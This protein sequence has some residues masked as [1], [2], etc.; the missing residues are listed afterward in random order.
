[1]ES[2]M[3]D[4]SKFR[5]ITRGLFT[6]FVLK[7]ED[8]RLNQPLYVN[9]NTRALA[10]F[11]VRK[12]AQIV[13][14]MEAAEFYSE[15]L[16]NSVF[17]DSYL[18]HLKEMAGRASGLGD[19]AFLEFGVASGTTIRLIAGVCQRPVVGFDWFKGLPENWRDGRQAGSFS[20]E[21]P[22]VPENVSLE[23]GLIEDTLPQWLE[24]SPPAEINFIHVDTDLYRPAKLIL[25]QCAPFMNNTI[26]VFDEFYNYPGWK[27]HE[28]KAFNEFM[29]E[30]PEFKSEYIGAG[31]K[32]SVSVHVTR[33][34]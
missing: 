21:I 8:K 26:I 3:G 29:A 31:G 11:D 27:H 28:Y 10:S 2:L 5:N 1:M 33:I 19:G 6:N 15:H 7:L 14:A 24:R 30:H 13:S 4:Q 16:Y 12:F 17:F 34:A 20:G 22:K 23:I 18:D 32:V 25:S 9:K